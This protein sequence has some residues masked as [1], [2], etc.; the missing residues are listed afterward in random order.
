M[1]TTKS[2]LQ[3]RDEFTVGHP[4]VQP[5]PMMMG[6]VYIDSWIRL[7]LITTALNLIGL[8][9]T[10]N[11]ED[12]SAESRLRPSQWET[13]LQ[14]NAVSH[15]LGANLGSAL[16]IESSQTRTQEQIEDDPFQHWIS[17]SYSTNLILSSMW[18][19]IIISKAQFSYAF[20]WL[21]PK[22]FT[23]KTTM[24]SMFLGILVWFH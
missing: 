11:R 2:V 12:Y 15:W 13:L 19:L 5:E 14:S 16:N 9:S 21:I 6:T 17:Y 24:P 20:S 4:A 23:H 22:T 10:N 3:C 7:V 18:K 8:D 1:D